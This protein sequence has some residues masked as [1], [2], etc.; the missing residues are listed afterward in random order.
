MDDFLYFFSFKD[1]NIRLVVFGTMLLGMV[2]ALVGSFNFWRKQALVGDVL[3][4]AVLPG[5]CLASMLF[6]TKSWFW[7][8]SGAM[9]SSS[10]AFWCI[11]A[12]V[13]YSKL[14]KDAA[15]ALVLSVF[16]GIGIFL[17]SYIQGLDL[18]NQSGLDSILLGKTAALQRLDIWLF[19]SLAGVL[20]LIFALFFGPLVLYTFDAAFAQ[21]IGL[22]VSFM[23]FLLMILTVGAIVSGIQAIGLI[24]VAALLISPAV[25]AKFWTC[26]LYV[27]LGLAALFGSLSALIGAYISYT[28]VNAPTGPWIVIVLFV[29]CIVSFVF[30]PQTGWLHHRFQE[31]RQRKIIYQENLLKAF[32]LLGEGRKNFFIPRSYT[33]VYRL[34]PM[35]E[36]VMQGVLATLQRKKYLSKYKKNS[37]C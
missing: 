21:S 2:C 5:V 11:E 25:V 17:L 4:H 32:Y 29:F 6:S 31:I 19:A 12:I 37:G 35:E 13:R 36:N 26:K 28:F 1:A 27:F 9:L 22:P 15:L 8:L 33:D 18:P 24:L 30:A 20:L 7:L 14:K 34:R 23:R 16:F 3:A 10:L